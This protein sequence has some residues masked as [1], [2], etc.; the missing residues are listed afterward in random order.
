M[1]RE[2]REVQDPNAAQPP[3]AANDA[4][5][6]GNNFQVLPVDVDNKDAATAEAAAEAATSRPISQAE[7][8]QLAAYKGPPG[9]QGKVGQH[10][11]EGRPGP[12]GP[13]GKPGQVLMGEPGPHGPRG[14]HGDVGLKGP[15][16]PAGP[17]GVQGMAYNADALADSMLNRA[18]ELVQRADG[19]AQSHDQTSA[20]LL[21]QIRQM[22]KQMGDDVGNMEHSSSLLAGVAAGSGRLQEEIDEYAR[23]VA[24]ARQGASEKELA[25]AATEI[26]VRTEKQRYESFT[27]TEV[28][29]SL[30]PLE[31]SGSSAIV[32]S[33]VFLLALIHSA[34]LM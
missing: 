18:R 6:N 20:M 32:P 7:A 27:K 21:M 25:E 23:R 5:M 19:L 31:K 12:R 30:A 4:G 29:K 15:H 16:G 13:P 8:E 3:A 28:E 10:G 9:P 33:A 34:W 14:P 2:H 17:T 24:L 26:A 1:R 22:E 11:R